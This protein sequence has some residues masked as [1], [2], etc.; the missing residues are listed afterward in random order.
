MTVLLIAAVSIPGSLLA[1]W[2]FAWV[3]GRDL[4]RR[5]TPGICWTCGLPHGDVTLT[6]RHCQEAMK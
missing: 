5:P 1:A 6:C 4:P 2:S 3:A